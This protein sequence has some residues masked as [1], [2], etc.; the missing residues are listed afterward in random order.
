VRIKTVYG[1]TGSVSGVTYSG[2]T[3]SNITKYGIVIEQG[4]SL[5]MSL[6]SS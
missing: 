2:I 5:F 6:S 4:M 3:L 1:A